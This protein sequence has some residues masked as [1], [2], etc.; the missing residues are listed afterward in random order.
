MLP[1]FAPLDMIKTY[2]YL[3]C[4]I[5]KLRY[6]SNIV[7]NCYVTVGQFQRELDI[8]GIDKKNNLTLTQNWQ[9]KD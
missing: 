3:L 6:Q 7:Y 9:T 1:V 4:F 5:V 8:W 2:G